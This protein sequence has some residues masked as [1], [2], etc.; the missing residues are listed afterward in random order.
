MAQVLDWL[1]QTGGHSVLICGFFVVNHCP[2]NVHWEIPGEI[3]TLETVVRSVMYP[4]LPS[5][6]AQAMCPALVQRI[7]A[8]LLP[9]TVSR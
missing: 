8:V 5:C 3:A 9:T 2:K 6:P 4:Q 1:L 7:H